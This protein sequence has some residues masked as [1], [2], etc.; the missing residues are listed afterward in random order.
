M[1][2][3][4]FKDAIVYFRNTGVKGLMLDSCFRDLVLGVKTP[5]KSGCQENIFLI[6]PRKHI[7][8]I[9]IRSSSVRYF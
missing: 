1:D 7:L 4:I 8:W 3:P 5:D 6:S 9:H 2:V